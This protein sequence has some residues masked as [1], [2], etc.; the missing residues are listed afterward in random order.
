MGTNSQISNSLLP[1]SPFPHFPKSQIS[2][3]MTDAYP[4][5][6]LAASSGDIETVRGLLPEENTSLLNQ[7]LAQAAAL[8]H[9][10]TADVLIDAGA[11]PNGEY[12]SLYGTVLFPA[13][14]YMNP[15]GISYLLEKEANP[16]REVVRVEGPRNALQHLLHSHHVSPHKQRC[17]QLLLQAGAPDPMDA[18]FAIHLGSMDRLL[19]ALDQDPD[20]L[21]QPLP[22]TYGR[23]PLEGGTLLHMAVE[24]NQPHLA[25]ELLARGIDINSRAQDLPATAGTS[26]VWPT[27]LI[28][29]GKQTAL[30]HAT[31]SSKVLLRFL[32]DRDADPSLPACFLRDGKEINLTPL[33]F[34]EEV[35][36]IE[37]NLL[38]EVITLRTFQSQR[39]QSR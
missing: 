5:L 11:D 23:F 15:E 26:P 4:P 21:T 29:M 2:Q 35:D 20:L 30:F 12:D 33:E 28:A 27:D 3:T 18:G 34:F 39:S 38:E 36:R 16:A 10:E 19:K 13:C 24:Y 8:S 37:C 25:E 14:E 1:D 7:A 17:I 31:A 32:L 22:H 6:F 9:F